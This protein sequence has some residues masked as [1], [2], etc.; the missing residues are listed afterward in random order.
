MTFYGCQI[1]IGY[2]VSLY[3]NKGRRRC[4]GMVFVEG[5]NYFAKRQQYICM[6]YIVSVCEQTFACMCVCMC[7]CFLCGLLVALLRTAAKNSK[8]K[9]DI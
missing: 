7:M 1:D 3:L 8:G 5:L 6:Y 9:E 4:R 2:R